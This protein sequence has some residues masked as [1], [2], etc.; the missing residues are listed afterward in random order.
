MEYIKLP[1]SIGTK[2]VNTLRKY[3]IEPRVN[4]LGLLSLEFTQE[5]LNMI[6][7]LEISNP[8]KGCLK[9]IENLKCLEKLTI[10]TKG[11]TAYEKE[12]SSI[13]D[14]DIK[15]ISMLS[16]LKTLQIDNQR[17]ITWL[18]L[19]DLVNL[20]EL[21]V[22]RNTSLE[23]ITGLE[24]LKKLKELTEC[25]N[26]ELFTIDNLAECINQNELDFLELDLLHYDEVVNNCDKI[27]S[28]IN[29]SFS[30]VVGKSKVSYTYYQLL[31]FHKKCLE[32]AK[33][34][35]EFSN[36]KREKITYLEHLLAKNI[37]YD[38]DGR[39]SEN[40][41]HVEDGKQRGYSKGVN[42]AYNGIMYGSAV[43]EGYTRS[44]QYILKLMGIKSKNVHCI[45]GANRITINEA[46]H[47]QVSLPD[48]D[49]HS[50]I[51]VEDPNYVYY[52]D[53]CWD[54][55]RYHSGDKSLPYCLLTK[56]EMSKT[57]TMSFEEDNIIFD[58]NYP[59][60]NIN[61]VLQKMKTN[62]QNKPEDAQEG[63]SR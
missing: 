54:S 24:K 21:I 56:N 30:E 1:I 9:G 45:G 53:P 42:S 13:D 18:N 17:G 60:E 39:D 41:A 2:V 4:E 38:Y 46:Y 34:S 5:E 26:K 57:H 47:D 51:R 35:D 58:M 40:R 6:K 55:S 20:E 32:Y 49:Y 8:Q 28:M 16:S 44:M 59:R 50:I 27:K 23:Q 52:C 25:G 11:D 3:G 62:Q 12:P 31:L 33:Q 48:R 61:Y 14:K 22:T 37:T 36:D 19:D 43:C 7:E 10:K 29:C 63:R 15:L